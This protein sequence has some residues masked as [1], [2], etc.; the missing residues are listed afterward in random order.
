M[1]A[2]RGAPIRIDRL[3]ERLESS[4]RER[5]PQ[6]GVEE[7]LSALGR[8]RFGDPERL[9][10][11]HDALLYFSAFPSRPAVRRQAESILRAFED[12]VTGIGNDLGILEDAEHSG[13]VGTS[14]TTSFSF[15]LLL[16]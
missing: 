11:F 13:V 7:A 3:L 12:R 9:V 8:S 2:S 4:R 1:P 6:R 16:R 14:V 15:D 5:G 10:R